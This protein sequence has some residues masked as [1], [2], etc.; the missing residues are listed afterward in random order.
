MTMRDLLIRGMLVGVLAGLLAFA[1]A[2]TFGEP[3]VDRAIAFEESMHHESEA[4]AAA[5]SAAQPMPGMAGMGHDHAADGGEVELVSR[6]TQAGIGLFTGVMAYSIAFGGLF[7]LAFGVAWGRV[8]GV[9]PKGL[10][11]LIATLGYVV[12]VVVPQL[13][14]PA[15]PP[16][17]G[18]PETIGHR[19]EL[20]FLMLLASLV[21]AGA[22]TW[23]RAQVA[24]SLG[25]WNAT[26]V[27]G[28][29]FIVVISV[30]MVALPGINEVP[31]GFP[32]QTLWQFRVASLGTEAILWLTLGIVFGF[33]TERHIAD[34]R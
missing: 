30:A 7:A 10:A 17:V 33:L 6:P 12:I 15:N 9:G 20:F 2:R 31:S 27:A 25:A 24:R 3:D 26:L 13:K 18:Q 8:R 29:G 21:A 14:Y 23:V 4:P 19:T 32:A 22:A 28:V 11:A 1:F 16:S 34:R 5:D